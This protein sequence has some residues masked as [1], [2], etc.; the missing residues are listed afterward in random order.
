MIM[1]TMTKTSKLSAISFL[2]VIMVLGTVA[3]AFAA[4]LNIDDSVEA[5]ITLAHDA[6]WEFGVDS[7][8]TPFGNSVPG[9]TVN[10]GETVSFTGTWLV[11]SGGSPDPGAGIIHV[12]DPNTGRVSDIIT[13]TWSTVP[14]S[15]F[16]IAT[17]D[18]LV[19]SSA[20]C[21]DLGELPA[22][23]TGVVETGA[24]TAIQGSF[25]D[26]GTDAP[27][28]IPSNLTIQFVSGEECEPEIEKTLVGGPEEIGISLPIATVYQYTIVYTGFAALVTDTVPAEFE[29]LSLEATDGTAVDFKPGKGNKSQ[30]S[31]KIEWQAPAGTSTLTVEIQTVE[32]P[33]KGHKLTV[34]KPTSCGPL[35]INDG[36]TAFEVDENGNLVLVE[37]TDPDTGEITLEPVVI[38]GPSNSLEVEAVEGAKPCVEVSDPN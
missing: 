11:N 16:D 13:A 5:S 30:S 12:L 25:R 28:S 38:V 19:N 4:N 36:A 24:S 7:N 9:V 23:S 20:K 32:S 29:V 35:P 37:V 8:G 31:T 10:P 22:G 18:I 27:V 21:S 17:I 15:P 3:P 33:G 1:K 14:S 34:F 26:S 2:S 6:N